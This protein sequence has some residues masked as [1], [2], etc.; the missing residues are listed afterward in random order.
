MEVMALN[1]AVPIFLAFSFLE[2]C[3]FSVKHNY[4]TLQSVN[5]T[6][7]GLRRCYTTQLFLCLDLDFAY[8]LHIHGCL[9]IS[10]KLMVTS[11]HL[12]SQDLHLIQE[13][14]GMTC[15]RTPSQVFVYLH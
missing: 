6:K 13:L 10:S 3:I 14:T 7:C 5:K 2:N 15:L 4:F 12:S 8:Y 11:S 1:L 9:C